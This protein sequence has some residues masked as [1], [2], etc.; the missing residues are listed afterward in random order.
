MASRRIAKSTFNW[1]ALEERVQPTQKTNYT[2]LRAKSNAYLRAVSANP[3][4]PPKLDWEYYKAKI[5]IPGL[6]E[7]FKKEYEAHKT[8]YPENKMIAQ[9][10]QQI[11]ETKC[12]IE[13]FKEQSE[14][15]IA[16]YQ[17]SVAIIKSKV[18][19]DQMTMEDYRAEFP[20]LAI[21]PIERPTFWP[22]NPE[23]Q[24]DYK[25]MEQQATTDH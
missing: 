9:I 22:H 13:E 19:F 6:V 25:S 23:E 16:E 10:E 7:N 12:E 5:S 4:S 17:K 8:P 24:L 15:R 21:D 18:A 2:A 3:E 20:D 11:E 14:E 1:K